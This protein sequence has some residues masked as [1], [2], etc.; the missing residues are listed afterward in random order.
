ALHLLP[1]E[2][3][4]PPRPTT[5]VNHPRRA[6]LWRHPVKTNRFSDAVCVPAEMLFQEQIPVY[7]P[8]F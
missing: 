7:V 3:D 2:V 1:E 4:L 6:V 5:A 8:G